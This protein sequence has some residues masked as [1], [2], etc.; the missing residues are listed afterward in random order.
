MPDDNNISNHN[1][2]KEAVESGV[3]EVIR[4]L[5]KFLSLTGGQSHVTVNEDGQLVITTDDVRIDITDIEIPDESSSSSSDSSASSAS[6]DSSGS[7]ASSHSSDSSDGL[8]RTVHNAYISSTSGL[9]TRDGTSETSPVATPARLQA[10]VKELL[11]ADPES[12][13]HVHLMKG[14][15]FPSFGRWDKVHGHDGAYISFRSYGTGTDK[16]H[17]ETTSANALEF[18]RETSHI[19]V[20]DLKISGTY[21]TSGISFKNISDVAVRNCDFHNASLSVTPG[22]FTGR[23]TVE[24]VDIDG[25]TF[26]NVMGDPTKA[27]HRQSVFLDLCRKW[28]FN[29]NIIYRSGFEA[30]VETPDEDL[31]GDIHN[32]GLYATGKCDPALEANHNFF[33]YCAGNGAQFR[34][35]GNCHGNVMIWNTRSAGTWGRTYGAPTQTR[36]GWGEF[37]GN[38]VGGVPGVVNWAVGNIEHGRIADNIFVGPNALIL[39]DEHGPND[40]GGQRVGLNNLIVENN[41]CRST[42]GA[43]IIVTNNEGGYGVLYD[44]IDRPDGV[45]DPFGVIVRNNRVSN[46]V[47]GA[48][49]APDKNTVENNTIEDLSQFVAPDRTPEL[50]DAIL[51]REM[52]AADFIATYG[53]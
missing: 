1:Q 25:N 35:G 13:V 42:D 34:S 12:T 46:G 47:S 29:N 21:G 16:P 30:T 19:E 27:H 52:T 26:V 43:G 3:N 10:V 36:G 8:G 50:V 32:Q 4:S 28:K 33:M 24:N 15:T 22:G 2:F 7:S 53:S 44:Y 51:N 45:E 31:V 39:Y 14:D 48:A 41:I 11:L 40:R 49:V 37:T 6:S 9:D 5:G 18:W 38:Y 20:R 23:W 17:I